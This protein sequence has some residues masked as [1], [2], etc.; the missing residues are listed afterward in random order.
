LTPPVL[1]FQL[2]VLLIMCIIGIVSIILDVAQLKTYQ[3]ENIVEWTFAFLL[4]MYFAG[5]VLIWRNYRYHLSE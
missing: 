4:N 5:M 2:Y 3:S 1:N